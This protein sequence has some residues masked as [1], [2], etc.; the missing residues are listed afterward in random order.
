VEGLDFLG[1]QKMKSNLSE[2]QKFNIGFSRGII[3]LVGFKKK[4]RFVVASVTDEA[5][6]CKG[7]CERREIKQ[8]I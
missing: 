8:K 2:K 1:K 6:A 5:Q 7:V 4:N 3:I